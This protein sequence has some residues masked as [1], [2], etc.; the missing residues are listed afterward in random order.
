MPARGAMWACS[1]WMESMRLTSYTDYALRTLMHLA[2][3]RDRLV[4]V[5]DIAEFHGIAKN[6]LTKVVHHLGVLGMIETVRGRN[7]GLRLG[8]EPGAINIGDLVRK[9]ESDF[10]QAS[11]VDSLPDDDSSGT[12]AD[13]L[14]GVL[15]C[16]TDAYLKVLD[17][18]TLKNLMKRDAMRVVH[19]VPLK[20]IQVYPRPKPIQ[21]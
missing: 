3:N 15:H 19:T 17:N 2:A 11:C 18:V 5:R 6:H 9:T 20:T 7:G 4:T 14:R 16:A 10:Y 12:A 1:D 21:H 13:G 8:R